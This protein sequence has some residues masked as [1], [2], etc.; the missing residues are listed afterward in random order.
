MHSE[1]PPDMSSRDRIKAANV[2]VWR[3]ARRQHLD[4]LLGD[5]GDRLGPDPELGWIR[6]IR[7][8][9]GMSGSELGGQLG[10][11]RQRVDQLE[12]AEVART[13]PMSTLDR[14]AAALGCRV[15]YFF[16][17]DEPF[18]Q[19]VRRQA[20]FR[21][22]AEINASGRRDPADVE[23]E[24][25]VTGMLSMRIAALAD[26]LVDR[27]GLWTAQPRRPPSEPS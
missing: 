27:R 20:L 8:A 4:Q 9:L 23:D 19:M 17:P 14:V 6:V 11:S 21:A 1:V 7:E 3:A 16:A 10:V 5:L 26:D 15:R 13:M 18:E 12:E 24:A 2:G 22:A 25:M